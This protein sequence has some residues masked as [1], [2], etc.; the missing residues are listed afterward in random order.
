V[1]KKFDRRFVTIF[2]DQDQLSATGYKR[3]GG[4]VPGTEGQPHEIIKGGSHFF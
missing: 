2:T 4:T 3:F 1:I